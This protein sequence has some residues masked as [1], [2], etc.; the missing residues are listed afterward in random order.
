MEAPNEKS[1]DRFKKLM[2]R[3]TEGIVSLSL[4]DDERFYL[5]KLNEAWELPHLSDTIPHLFAL[6]FGGIFAR[7]LPMDT[8]ALPAPTAK[9]GKHLNT[10]DAF[11]ALHYSE[12]IQLSDLA[13]ALFLCP[14]QT[15]RIVQKAYGCSFSE[16]INRQ[17]LGA[18]CTML[19]YTDLEIKEIAAQVGY[20]YDNYFYTV[21]RKAY[22]VT[23]TQYRKQYQTNP[24][25]QKKG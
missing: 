6:L 1:I 2:D 5:N 9:Y 7:L 11:L 19:Q 21:F 13:N 4:S 17:R 22:K 20:E 8:K 15:S 3:L 18:A 24:I 10:I 12:P 16:L 23:P 25:Y 14:K